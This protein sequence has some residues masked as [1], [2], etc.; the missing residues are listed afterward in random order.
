MSEMDEKRD[1]R[2]P[3]SRR[4]LPP[5]LKEESGW[6]RG[7]KAAAFWIVLLLLAIF[8]W[9]FFSPEGK[10]I[11]NISY[12]DFIA[13]VD[14]ENVK[15]ATIY[16]KTIKGEFKVKITRTDPNSGR[17]GQ[18]GRYQLYIPFEDPQLLERLRSHN[19]EVYAQS[20]NLNWGTILL[21]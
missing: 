20:E 15:K 12:S 13:E 14:K 16:E 1:G 19:A 3:D 5:I 7:G 8:A 17:T 11:W 2:G 4:R 21:S 18:Y 9:R 10:D 6:K